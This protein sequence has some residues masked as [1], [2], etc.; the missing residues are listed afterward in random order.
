MKSGI[1]GGLLRIVGVGVASS[2]SSPA[3]RQ[4]R[5]SA[6]HFRAS[7]KIRSPYEPQLSMALQK[8]FKLSERFDLQ[9]RGE[10]F[11]LTNPPIFPGPSTDIFTKPKQLSNGSYIGLGTVPYSQQNFPRNVQM[12]FKLLF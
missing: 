6:R 11:N 4:P 8:R 2:P 1:V 7:L 9:F 12:S 3:W 5:N 10:A